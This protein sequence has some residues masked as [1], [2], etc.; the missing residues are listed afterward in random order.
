MFQK[1]N[2]AA[3]LLI[4][5]YISLPQHKPIP[6]YYQQPWVGPQPLKG[7]GKIGSIIK[8]LDTKINVVRN[9]YQ[10]N[11]FQNTIKKQTVVS[12]F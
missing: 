3:N 5:I 1:I 4:Y 11:V 12:I 8:R 6:V 9:V 7:R 10:K 2:A